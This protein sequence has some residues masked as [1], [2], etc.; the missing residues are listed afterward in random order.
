ML[1]F[2]SKA[3]QGLYFIPLQNHSLKKS[4]YFL[5][6]YTF[7]D[8]QVSFKKK[9]NNDLLANITYQVKFKSSKLMDDLVERLDD[10]ATQS[11]QII[12]VTHSNITEYRRQLKIKAVQAAKEKGI[13]LTEAIGEKLGDA[14]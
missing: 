10:N 9:K 8:L 4:E 13:Y 2:F 11:F 12:S 7:P 6:P 1:R 14:I 5:L 3:G